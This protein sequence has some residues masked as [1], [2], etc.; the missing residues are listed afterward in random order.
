M[1]D[2]PNDY[3]IEHTTISELTLP[4]IL[5]HSSDLID[6]TSKTFY[7]IKPETLELNFGLFSHPTSVLVFPVV[8]VSQTNNAIVVSCTC[9]TVK[10]RLCNHQAQVLLN[11]MKRPALRAFFDTSLRQ[12]TIQQVSRE[13]GMENEPDLD[14][15]F[16]ITY[17]N[18]TLEVVPKIKELIKTTEQN[19]SIFKEQLL[20]QKRTILDDLSKQETKKNII[21]FRKH[22]YYDQLTIE[23]YEAPTTKDGNIKNPLTFIDPLNLIWQTER[24]ED[25]KFYTGISKF[26]NNYTPTTPSA[27]IE[28]L[29]L[30]INNP[31]NLGVYYHDKNISEKISTTSIVPVELKMLATDIKLSVFKKEPFYEVE[32]EFVVNSQ[33]YPFQNAN[34]KYNYFI[35]LGNTLNLIADTDSLK[36]LQFFKSNNQKV[37]I[38]SSKYDEFYR[39]ILEKLEHQISISY[40]FIKPATQKQL[41]QQ[42]FDEPTQKIIYLSD[43]GSYISI[44]P[45][46]KYGNIE[47]PVFSRKQIFD[48]DPNGNVFK[49][50]RDNELETRFTS[51]LLRQH[52]EFEEQLLESQYF[53]LHKTKFLD[54]SW[55]LNAFEEW[56]NQEIVILGFNELKKN[57]L[58]AHK[59]KIN[60]RVNSGLDWFNC[61]LTVSYGKQKP[62]PQQL[63][64]AIR[65]KSKFVQLDDGTLGILPDEWMKKF[66]SYFQ[67]GE[68]VD[69]LLKIPKSNFTSISTLFD[70]SMLDQA[71]TKE[72]A[73]YSTLLSNFN[74]IPEVAIPTGLKATLR[75]YQYQGLKWLNFLDDYNFGA[76]L[77]DDMGLGKT[78]QIIAF[79]L[80]QRDKLKSKTRNN[81]FNNTNLIVVPTSLLFNWQA[82]VAKFAPGIKLFTHY[83]ANRIKNN[84]DFSEYEIVLTTYG[85]LLS[86]IRFLKEHAFNYIFLDE[87]QAIKNPE[88]QR[89]KVARMLQ[90]RN[91]VVITG[92]PVENNTFDIYGQLSFACPGLLGNKQYFKEIYSEPIDNFED[93]KRAT[94]L[95][96]KIKPFILRRTKKEIAKELPEKTEMV[97][98]CEMGTEQ[99]HVYNTY[100]KELR[101]Y[102]SAKKEDEIAKDS[103]HVLTGLTKLRQICNSPALIKEDEHYGDASSK[104]DILME[105]IE[106]KS[107][108]HKILV[109]S[110]FVSMLDLV[111]KELEK[112]QIPFEYLTGKTKNRASAVNEFQQNKDVRVF[113]ISL[114]AG[115]VGLNLTEADYVYLIDP[116]WNPAVE[117]Q[118]I[119]RCYR[120][121]QKKNV[122]AVRLICPD[123]I[124]EKIMKLQE[125]KMKLVNDL[126][127]TD[128]AM[129]KSF[130]KT[131]LLTMLS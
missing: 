89:Y 72:L 49:V 33:S 55:F 18:N 39:N 115:G 22:K 101:D 83:G 30:I 44:T 29:K 113:L 3:I 82:E 97:I 77:A 19:K 15:F 88:S 71:V 21:V 16:E 118:A 62:S 100:E 42:N 126:I 121:G 50:E 111:K 40:R 130:S 99:R 95:Q 108:Q 23:L 94:E 73:V 65:N 54:E 74:G 9:K 56:Q 36:L 70:E 128:G 96:Q 80:S 119:D 17:V 69:D 38:H 84:A 117:N 63:Y 129:L 31:L 91:K 98:Y 110:Q 45:V 6:T 106:N 57:N 58:N 87:S 79:I 4:E 26:Q 10:K 105:H 92:T 28:V 34:I 107:A 127:K 114:K 32:G 5:K 125:S 35:L 27:D 51:I 85:T 102:I 120:I 47:I 46:M 116:W 131:D 52:P 122:I 12:Q 25:A 11:I 68:V 20:P 86:D 59:A 123:T 103:M 8:T 14:T 24:I 78:I 112:K 2:H 90:S 124:E 43:E 7:D 67:A 37:I 81:K 64:K 76:C 48:S 61:A 75:D 109:F 104:I 1:R 93:R 60:I 53:Y 66:A 41:V 13:Y